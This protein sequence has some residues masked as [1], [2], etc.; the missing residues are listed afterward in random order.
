MGGE[1]EGEGSW[2]IAGTVKTGFKIGPFLFC[3]EMGL[4]IFEVFILH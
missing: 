3:I 4:L 2:G 1:G